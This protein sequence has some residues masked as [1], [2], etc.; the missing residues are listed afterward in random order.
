MYLQKSLSHG[1]FITSNEAG[2][3]HEHRVFGYNSASQISL[4]PPPH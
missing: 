4:S 1:T 3:Q 2:D